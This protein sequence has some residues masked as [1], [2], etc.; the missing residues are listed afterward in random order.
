MSVDV[1]QMWVVMLNCFVNFGPSGLIFLNFGQV[2][3][4]LC[5]VERIAIAKIS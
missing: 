3:G 2:A 1:V 4:S 5:V